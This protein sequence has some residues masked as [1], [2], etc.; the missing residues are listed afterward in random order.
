MLGSPR[1]ADKVVVLL[2]AGLDFALT[3]PCLQYAE[4]ARYF[5]ANARDCTSSGAHIANLR[6]LEET[7]VQMRWL[8]RGEGIFQQV[9]SYPQYKGY[10]AETSAGVL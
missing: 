10:C 5:V 3:I 9:D 4:H 1:I 7:V 6:T 8:R 2:V